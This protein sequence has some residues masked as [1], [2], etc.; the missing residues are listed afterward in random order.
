MFVTLNRAHRSIK[1]FS[2]NQCVPINGTWDWKSLSP[3]LTRKSLQPLS[4]HLRD[5][6]HKHKQTHREANCD[7]SKKNKQNQKSGREKFANYRTETMKIPFCWCKW[8]ENIVK[9]VSITTCGRKWNR[10]RHRFRSRLL[11]DR[12]HRPRQGERERINKHITLMASCF[13][14]F[15][16]PQS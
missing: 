2:V 9:L 5:Y 14:T 1:F 6:E 15:L 8:N 4:R 12:Q 16:G 3:S 11:N 7:N 10:R 13:G